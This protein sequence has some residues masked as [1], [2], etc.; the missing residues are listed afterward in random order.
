MIT[1]NQSSRAP[2]NPMTLGKFKK[3]CDVME[4]YVD[5]G[6]VD[7]AMKMMRKLTSDLKLPHGGTELF[8][9]V[10]V[11]RNASCLP[12]KQPCEATPC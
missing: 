7:E 3:T 4:G 1:P 2:S 9:N 10:L 12:R 5:L 11:D 6:M 8:A